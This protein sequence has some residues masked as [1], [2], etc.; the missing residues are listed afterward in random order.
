[1]KS[2]LQTVYKAMQNWNAAEPL[3]LESLLQS[4]GVPFE[5]YIEALEHSATR[6]MVI[7]KRQVD[8]QFTNNYNPLFMRAWQA[9]MDIQL[10]LD[11]YACVTWV[12]AEVIASMKHEGY[13]TEY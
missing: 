10:A 7:L 12:K 11:T 6:H 8:E 13:Y 1:M 5:S 2:I 3:T 4:V 9:N